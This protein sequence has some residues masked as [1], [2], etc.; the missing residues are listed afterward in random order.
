MIPDSETLHAEA[1]EHSS[2]A[3]NF[4]SLRTLSC[5]SFQTDGYPGQIAEAD[6]LAMKSPIFAYT[7]LIYHKRCTGF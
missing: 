7:Y 3:H 6:H 1:A 5:R 2:L 4:Q